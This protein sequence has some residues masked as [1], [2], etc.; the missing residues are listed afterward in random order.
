MPRDSRLPRPL[1]LAAAIALT[2]PLPTLAA[3]P[4]PVPIGELMLNASA[5]LGVTFYPQA[6]DVDAE[7]YAV[8]HRLQRGPGHVDGLAGG[9]RPACKAHFVFPT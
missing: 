3:A 4:Q 8:L 2:L 7:A 1:Q 9:I 5:S 6:D